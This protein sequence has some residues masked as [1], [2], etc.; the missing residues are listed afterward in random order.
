MFYT[1]YVLHQYNLHI[2]HVVISY[3]R[4]L[5]KCSQ[6]FLRRQ[7]SKDSL[8][9]VFSCG[10]CRLSSFVYTTTFIN[11]SRKKGPTVPPFP[12]DPHERTWDIQSNEIKLQSTS[13][14]NKAKFSLFLLLINIQFILNLVK[15]HAIH[16]S[17][18][19]VIAKKSL[20]KILWLCV[21]LNNISSSL[22]I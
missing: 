22:Q 21:V 20:N 13:N 1:S 3:S 12:H 18:K 7:G 15:K 16:S 10:G 8:S 2:R 14:Q 17:L 6:T 4:L 19:Q 5:L 11:K 9:I